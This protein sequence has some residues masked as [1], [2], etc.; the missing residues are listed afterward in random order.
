MG[1]TNLVRRFTHDE[2]DEDFKS[3]VG[4]E[5]STRRIEHDGKILKAQ[6][7]DTGARPIGLPP[8]CASRRGPCACARAPSGPATNCACGTRHSQLGKNASAQA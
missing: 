3:T 5:F 1:K 6:I 8:F 2:F 7:W 4:I